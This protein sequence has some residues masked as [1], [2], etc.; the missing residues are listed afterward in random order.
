M[1]SLKY[2]ESHGYVISS[3]NEWFVGLNQPIEEFKESRFATGHLISKIHKS[4]IVI[5][6]ISYHPDKNELFI[7]DFQ[8]KIENRG[9]G[10]KALSSIIALAK[11]LDCKYIRG[12][13]GPADVDHFDKLDYFYKKH[14]FIVN[15][16]S[17]RE[18]G[19]IVLSL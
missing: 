5:F 18:S 19:D 13:L 6:K 2:E 8:S 16:D 12:N 9:Y 14:G 11:I 7:C 4:Y 10:S 1:S 3:S 15:I 17:D